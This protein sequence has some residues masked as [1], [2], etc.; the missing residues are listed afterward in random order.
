LVNLVATVVIDATPAGSRNDVGRRRM[1]CVGIARI[2]ES[3]CEVRLLRVPLLQDRTEL[4]CLRSEDVGELLGE[5]CL[6]LTQHR[7]QGPLTEIPLQHPERDAL[8]IAIASER[9]EV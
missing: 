9:A 2:H 8:V 6:K 1:P 7:L 3:A 4:G 5:A